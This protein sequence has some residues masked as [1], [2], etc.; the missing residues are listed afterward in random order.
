MQQNVGY[1]LCRQSDSLC[2]FIWELI[3]LILRKTNCC[4]LLFLLLELGFFSCGYLLI[5][6]LKITFLCFLG[7]SFPPCVGVF[8]LLS[9]ERLDLWKCEFGF[10][11]YTLVSQC[12]VIDS[13]AGYSSQ[14]WH[15]CSL[16]VCVTSV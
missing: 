7:H 3:S 5:A 4:F 16:R 15:L 8:H 9:F 10:V 12:M 11:M 1:S 13:F 6:L 2:L 14:G